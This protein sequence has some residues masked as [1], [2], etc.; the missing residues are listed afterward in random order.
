MMN[1]ITFRQTFAL[2]AFRCNFERHLEH[3]IQH[4]QPSPGNK[5]EDGNAISTIQ[6]FDVSTSRYRS[7]HHLE[8][9]QHDSS[10]AQEASSCAEEEIIFS[11]TQNEAKSNSEI[12]YQS[13]E[14]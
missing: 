3:L 4:T 7:Q 1:Q 9:L 8:D 12:F 10:D 2:S 13:L 5:S 6:A 14:I 11:K